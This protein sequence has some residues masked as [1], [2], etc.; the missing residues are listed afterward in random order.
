MFGRLVNPMKGNGKITEWKEKAYLSG[1]ME[2]HIMV[3]T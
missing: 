2:E 1:L 3:T